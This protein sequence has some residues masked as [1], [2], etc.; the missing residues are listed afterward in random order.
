M[1]TSKTSDLDFHRLVVTLPDMFQRVRLFTRD[2]FRA[3]KTER[4]QVTHIRFDVKFMSMSIRTML[5]PAVW[6]PVK[7]NRWEMQR[8]RSH[9]NF[10]TKK[11]KKK[12][13]VTD[14]Y[15]PDSYH[16]T[17]EKQTLQ[18]LT[19]GGDNYNI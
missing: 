9:A 19:V 14:S 16:C 1:P 13:K 2:Y 6:S 15:P 5:S 17:E 18:Q 4:G 3:R 10:T 8:H 11:E 7:M 12:Q